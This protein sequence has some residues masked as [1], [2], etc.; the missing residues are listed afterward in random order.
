LIVHLLDGTYE[1]FRHFF[2]LPS[3]R[4]G[5]GRE[6][7]AVRGV[8]AS[9]LGMIRAGCTHISVATDPLIEVVP[10]P[11]WRGYKT[12]ARRAAS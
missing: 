1:L 12:S 11:L 3:A 6:V 10:E 8:I 2:A 7:A 4:D 9:V 5:E